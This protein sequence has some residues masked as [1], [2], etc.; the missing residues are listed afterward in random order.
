[1]QTTLFSIAILN[2]TIASTT[3]QNLIESLKNHYAYF[4]I[5]LINPI[6]LHTIPPPPDR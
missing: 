4:E 5:L 1:M 3:L 2:R 6:F